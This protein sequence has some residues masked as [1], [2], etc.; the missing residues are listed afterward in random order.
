MKITHQ[1][2]DT[3]GN[4]IDHFATSLILSDRCLFCNL[5][6]N[7]DIINAINKTN[8]DMYYKSLNKLYPCLSEEEYLIKKL[9]E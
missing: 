9:L 5:Q 3:I 2:V 8:L 4:I 6:I 1:F 7:Q